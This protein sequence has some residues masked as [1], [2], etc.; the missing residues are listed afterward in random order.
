MEGR[1]ISL[2]EKQALRC[3]IQEQEVLMQG[4]QKVSTAEYNIHQ[5][6]ASF[7]YVHRCLWSCSVVFTFHRPYLESRVFKSLIVA[8]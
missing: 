5:C 7:V 6:V 3:D 1:A 4:Y 2:E 8:L